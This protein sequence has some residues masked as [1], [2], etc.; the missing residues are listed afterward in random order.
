MSNSDG[1]INLRG[2]QRTQDGQM[3]SQLNVQLDSASL[4]KLLARFGEAD[5]VRGG[6]FRSTGQLEWQG[7][8]TSIQCGPRSVAKSTLSAESGQFTR[9][10]PGVG[11]LLGLTTL[12]SLGRRLRFDFKDVFGEGFAPLTAST[13]PS[14]W[15]TAWQR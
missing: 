3:R 5:L 2:V 6:K 1:Q 7:G 9:A 11:R 14:D 15:T 4:G 8:M 12:Q 10:E 13:A